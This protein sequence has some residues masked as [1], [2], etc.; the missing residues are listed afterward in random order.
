MPQTDEVGHK[1]LQDSIEIPF[2]VQ[3]LMHPEDLDNTK[4]FAKKIKI[5]EG[6]TRILF[7]LGNW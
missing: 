7:T 2:E 5:N 6:K 4:F 1:S 3:K